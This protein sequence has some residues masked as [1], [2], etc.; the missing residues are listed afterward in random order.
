MNTP[1]FTGT[2]I[3]VQGSLTN[4]NI[5]TVTSGTITT[6]TYMKPGV[7]KMTASTDVSSV[8]EGNFMVLTG[9]GNAGNNN[10]FIILGKSG[11]D[12]YVRHQVI[13][14]SGHTQTINTTY[15]ESAITATATFY[16][17][18]EKTMVTGPVNGGIIEQIRLT[19]YSPNDMPVTILIDGITACTLVL[20]PFEGCVGNA[21]TLMMSQNNEFSEPR[22][23]YIQTGAGAFPLT[24]SMTL[25]L[26]A[27][28]SN[29]EKLHYTVLGAQF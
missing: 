27:Y 7:V 22:Y 11:S 5:T 23:D 12:L 19:S 29:T 26:K 14:A 9:A 4:A 17:C 2:P 18:A 28:V 3:S 13:N 6:I 15:N 20:E 21:R 24:P 8:L 25:G 16:S 10:T 1:N